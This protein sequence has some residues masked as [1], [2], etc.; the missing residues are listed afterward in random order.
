MK[1]LRIVEKVRRASGAR[2]VPPLGDGAASPSQH[3]MAA[4]SGTARV[5]SSWEPTHRHRKGGLYRVLAQGVLETDR[6][7]AIIYDD[8]DGTIWIRAKSEFQDGRFERL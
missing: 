7:S 4:G 6:S 1:L 2:A 5:G 3:I 8:A